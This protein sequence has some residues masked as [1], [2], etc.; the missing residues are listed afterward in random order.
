MKVGRRATQELCQCKSN[1]MLDLAQR[2]I[3]IHGVFVL[4]NFDVMY[5][6][7]KV[8]IKQTFAGSRFAV[9]S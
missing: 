5:M 7:H 8:R 1:S 3:C 4:R 9:K 2:P 6:F